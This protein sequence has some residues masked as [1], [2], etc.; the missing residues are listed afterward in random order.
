MYSVKDKI[1]QLRNRKSVRQ[2][3]GLLSVNIIG[4]PLGIVTN[5]I[6]TRYMGAQ[7]YGDYKFI[8]SIFNIAYIIFSLGFFQAGNRALT[9]N[10]DK[11]EG[12]KIYG[13]M[14]AILFL[15]YIVMSIFMT[16]YGLFDNNIAEKGLT[17]FFV[18]VVP[19]CFIYL[20]GH[21]F[22]T[23]LPADNQIGLLARI[24]FVPKV[25]NL[26]LAGIL[27]IFF[28]NSG[29]N[30]LLIIF[31]IY[32]CTQ[33]VTYIY[34]FI[35]LKPSFADMR[36][37]CKSIFHFNKTY[38]FNVYLGSLFAV[39]FGSLTDI[40]ISYFGA[41]NTGVGFYSLAVTL[42]SPLTFVPATIATTNYKS[43]SVQN[44]ISRKLIIATL[45][46][47]VLTMVSLWL[48][49][50]P[51][52]KFFYGTDFL[53]VIRINFFVSI[54][55]LLYGISDFFNRFLGAKGQGKLLRNAS[56]IVGLGALITNL[57]FIPKFGEYGAAYAKLS[58]GLIYLITILYYYKKV[59]KTK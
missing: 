17:K 52:V 45:L 30:K 49:I 18:F 23:M 29:G 38:G 37:V 21:Y 31:L 7:L 50:P 58:A 40:L 42:T 55:V 46:I 13:S 19:L 51:F 36:P 53:P 4:I 16:V 8:V 39:G 32:T 41:D 33:L 56:F 11:E 6:V 20:W 59:T 43:L 14:F 27:Y 57:I 22:E 35:K 48:V 34:A 12:R 1:G 15:L 5:I 47:S 28:Y 26:V 44:R 54:G 10:T 9:L 2:I 3:A 24:R 25:L